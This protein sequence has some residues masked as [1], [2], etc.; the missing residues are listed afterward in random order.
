MF[1]EIKVK[2]TNYE[3]TPEVAEALKKRLRTLE[4]FI[5]QDETNLLCEV[6]LEKLN[7]QHAGRVFRAEINFTMGSA[8]LRAEALEERMEDA[9]DR[10]KDDLKREMRRTHGKKQSLMRRGAQRIKDL[11]RFGS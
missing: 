6:E 5:P 7:D 11:M 8:F 10:A 4:R 2:A 9:I 3:Y 1:P